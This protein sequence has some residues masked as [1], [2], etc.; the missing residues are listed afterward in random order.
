MVV[1]HRGGPTALIYVKCSGGSGV[2]FKR[3]T[4]SGG[5]S[6]RFSAARWQ[7]AD[8]THSAARGGRSADHQPTK[9]RRNLAVALIPP[10]PTVA[11]KSTV[12]FRPALANFH[13]SVAAAHR[14]AEPHIHQEILRPP[15]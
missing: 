6:S 8:R 4:R 14:L 10:G 13:S 12:I 15:N 5:N 9:A 1:K 3:G 2:V 11:M 7:V